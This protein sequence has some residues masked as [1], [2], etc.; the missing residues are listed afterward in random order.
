MKYILIIQI[1][2]LLTQDCYPPFSDR[3][4][5]DS[6]TACVEKGIKQTQSAIERS[7]LE[8]EKYKFIVKYW[9]SEDNSNKKPTSGKPIEKEV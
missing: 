2:S 3:Q 9:C 7:P 1:C 4:P 6:W 8:F 5:I